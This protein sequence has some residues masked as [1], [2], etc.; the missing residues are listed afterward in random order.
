MISPPDRYAFLIDIIC[1]KSPEFVEA[2]LNSC[3]NDDIAIMSL[4]LGKKLGTYSKEH[5]K[6]PEDMMED[7]ERKLAHI[8]NHVAKLY[9]KKND[10]ALTNWLRE[11]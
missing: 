1:N 7:A 3:T 6:I 2:F 10:S 9:Q 11:R 4:E 8:N 5:G